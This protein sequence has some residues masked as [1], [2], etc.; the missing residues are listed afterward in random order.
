MCWASLS[1]LRD[2]Q[3]H[4]CLAVLAVEIQHTCKKFLFSSGPLTLST[5]K[6]TTSFFISVLFFALCFPTMFWFLDT[7][8]YFITKLGS[9]FSNESISGPNY[10]RIAAVKFPQVAIELAK[11]HS[12]YQ[13]PCECLT[14]HPL[15]NF[16]YLIFF[17]YTSCIKIFLNLDHP[18]SNIPSFKDW[19]C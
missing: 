4:P 11:T 5:S 6:L 7:F 19:Y 2:R 3:Q 13:L 1:P 14:I 15:H 9:W 16:W 18:P 17:T 8:F 10:L 12:W